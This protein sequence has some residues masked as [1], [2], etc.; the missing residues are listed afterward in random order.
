MQLASQSLSADERQQICR[1]VAQAESVTSA[2]IVP[3]VATSSGRYDR[4]ED[5]VGLWF[6]AVALA[7][8]WI[9][10]P[11]VEREHGSWGG[12]PVWI[13]IA[14]LVVSMVLGFVI[15]AFL[16]SRVGWLRR[17]FTH[18]TMLREE[19]E[20]RAR[21]VFFDARVHHTETRGGMLIYVSLFERQ[22]VLL[23]DAAIAE[24]MGQPQID[25]LCGKLTDRLRGGSLSA[26]LCETITDCGQQLAKSLPRQANDVN[27]LP[28]A[29]VILDRP[30]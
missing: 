30:L 14:V 20:S 29:L 3:V 25:S 21:R 27:E 8:A 13:D 22:A 10:W 15:G 1:A 26:A 16:A 17:L 19:V 24:R 23:A 11:Q 28:D 12:I 2:E 9:V 4:A 18:R 5:M 7:I 6:G